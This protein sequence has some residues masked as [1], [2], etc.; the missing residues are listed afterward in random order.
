MRRILA[1][2][3]CFAVT[4]PSLAQEWP[5]KPIRFV[6]PW[7]AGGLNDLI[8]R[9]FNDRVAKALGQTVINDFKAGAGGRLIFPS[10]DA[11]ENRFP[12]GKPASG[13]NISG[14]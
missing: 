2:V 1:A 3:L 14:G 5:T 12:R 4:F 8:A 6:V 11:G 9:A 7:P 13:R 10:T